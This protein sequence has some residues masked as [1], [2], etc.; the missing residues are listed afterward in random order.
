MPQDAR[1]ALCLMGKLFAALRA[2][3]PDASSAG[4]LVGYKA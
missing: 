3:D 2:N 4:F 1:I